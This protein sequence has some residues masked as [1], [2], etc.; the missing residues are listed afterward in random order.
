MCVGTPTNIHMITYIHR[1]LAE[2]AVLTWAQHF[3]P[4]VKILEPFRKGSHSTLLLGEVG[5]THRMYLHSQNLL[6]LPLGTPIS[7]TV[8]FFTMTSIN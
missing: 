1:V 7:G 5:R 8:S 3:G 2:Y 6:G 4:G